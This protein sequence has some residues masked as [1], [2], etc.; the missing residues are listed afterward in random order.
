MIIADNNEVK[1]LLKKELPEMKIIL[2][3]I[4]HLGEGVMLEEEKVK[5]T[6][7]DFYLLSFSN[8]I[9][10]FSCNEHGSGFSYWCAVTFDIPYVSKFIN[11][12]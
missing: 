8:N 11:S 10:S 4:T 9:I 7:I 6:L 5:H 12:L 3:E 1:I 2:N